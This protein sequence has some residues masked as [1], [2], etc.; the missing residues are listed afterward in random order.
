MIH[1]CKLLGAKGIGL[2]KI[3][4]RVDLAQANL[5]TTLDK[6]NHR[7]AVQ[8]RHQ[9]VQA[10]AKLPEATTIVYC[11]GTVFP[12]ELIEHIHNLCVECPTLRAVMA[13]ESIFSACMFGK[14]WRRWRE[15][16]KL[17]VPMRY[18]LANR[19]FYLLER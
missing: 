13:T 12:D 16:G 15:R 6:Y 9:D 7:G 11:F 10:L 2:E 3:S 14:G 19:D 18:E 17:S 4:N 5:Q 1:A 8:L